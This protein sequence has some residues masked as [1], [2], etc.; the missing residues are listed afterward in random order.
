MAFGRSRDP[1]QKVVGVVIASYMT[2]LCVWAICYAIVGD[3]GM[4]VWATPQPVRLLGWFLLVKGLT[5]VVLAQAQMGLSWRM[6]VAPEPTALVV[7]GLFRWSRHPI[8]SGMLTTLAAYL[9]LSPCPWIVMG[10]F[11]FALLI[12]I[13]SAY[14]EQSM[15]TIHGAPYREYMARVGRFFPRWWGAQEPVAVKMNS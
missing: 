4:G 11:Q 13:Q 14:E 9:F 6:G 2:A 8:Y 7:T 12:V 3:S 10:W 15:I 5:L 1:I